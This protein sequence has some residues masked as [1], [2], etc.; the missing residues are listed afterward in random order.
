MKAQE[1][2]TAAPDE[3]LPG[4]PASSLWHHPDFLRFWFGETV[5]LFGSQV[6]NLAVPL[7]AIAT[8]HASDAQVGLLRFLQLAPYIGFAMIFGAWADRVRRRHVMIGTNLV[9]TA[10]VGL[11]PLLAALHAL[12]MPL[13]SAI[14]CAVGIA[15]VLFDVSWMP[16]APTL[17]ADRRQHVEVSA[18][19]GMSS[20]ASDVAGPGLAGLLVSALSAPTALLVDAASY[21]VSV[22]SLLTIRTKEPRP[23]PAARRNLPQEM[24]EGLAWVLRTRILRWLAL[25]GFCCNFS[26]ITVWT[27]FLLYGTHDLRLAPSVVGAVFATASVGGLLGALVSRAVIA[28]F[29]LGRV[30]FGAQTALLLGPTAIALAAG[31]KAVIVGLVTGSFFTT[32]LGLGIANVIIVSLRQATTPPALLSRMTACFRMLLFGG[33]ALGGLTAGLLSQAIGVRHA[34][35]AA[36]AFSAAVVVALAASPVCRLREL[37]R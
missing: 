12:S 18:K 3:A 26:M 2:T 16:Y 30:Y 33:G 20:S 22:A 15:S 19:M 5:S 9:R 29:P 13:L 7:T 28:R 1:S 27:M 8:F 25:I 21:A 11:V 31:P 23:T 36:A 32:Y 6:S 37:P 14:A 17:V 10:L 34:L 35:V 24:R 4:T